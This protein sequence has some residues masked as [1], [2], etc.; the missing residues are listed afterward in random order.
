[1]KIDETLVDHLA[2]LSRLSFEGEEKKEIVEDLNKI[3]GFVDQL[4][5]VNT[6]GV[7]PLVFMSDARN[8]MREDKAQHTVEKSDALKNA[9]HKDSDYFKIP[10]VL[11]KK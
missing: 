7:A 9:A 6:E 10:T 8:E 5:E 1:M 11:K 2:H 3:V 4:Q